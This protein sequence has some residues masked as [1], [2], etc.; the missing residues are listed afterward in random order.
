MIGLKDYQSIKTPEDYEYDEL[1]ETYF[2]ELCEEYSDEIAEHGM[3]SANKAGLMAR[4]RKMAKD[5]LAE[6]E[7][8]DD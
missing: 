4:A 6:V 3:S 5:R 2:K 8:E 7:N 1:V